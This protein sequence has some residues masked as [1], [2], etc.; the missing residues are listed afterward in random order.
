[1]TGPMTGATAR[2]HS[3]ARRL[4][5]AAVLWI[6]AALIVGGLLLSNLFRGPLEAAFEQRLGFLL[7]SLIS[8][9][10]I[11]PDGTVSAPRPL[12]EPRFLRQYSGL[13]WQ[14]GRLDE[15]RI[16]DRSRSMWDF[17]IAIGPAGGAVQRRRYAIDGPLGQRLGVIEQIVIED[18]V[19]GRFAFMVAADTAELIAAIEA[20]NRT[21]IWSLGALGIGLLVAILAQVYYGLRPLKRIRIALAD[22]RGGRSE[23]LEGAFPAEVVP[24]AD[25]LNGLLDH[26]AE[27][28]ARARAH[29]GN[30]A[31]ALKTPL[32]VLTNEASAPTPDIAATVGAQAALMRRQVDHHLARARIVGQAPLLRSHT[33][34]RPVLDAVARTLEKIHAERGIAISISGADRLGF[35]GEQHDLEEMLG[36]LVDNGCKWAR[37]EVRLIAAAAATVGSGGLRVTISIDDDGPGVPAAQRADLFDRGRRGDESTPGSGLGLSIVRDIAVL[38]GGGIELGDSPLGGLRATLTLPGAITAGDG[39]S[40]S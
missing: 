31:H 35:R 13:Y 11:A 12:G 40:P 22:I 33:D 10:D 3:I 30:L 7:Q 34:L 36:N 9:V 5:V 19:D 17:E 6:A 16:L 4:V 2:T 26:T 15:G 37:S 14:I 27:V 38:Y 18:G 39:A 32:A 23:R 8:V 24:L 28:L 21:L 25:E 20:F 1:M 29:V